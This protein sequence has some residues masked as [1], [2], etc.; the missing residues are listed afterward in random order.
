MTVTASA[1][2]FTTNNNNMTYGSIYSNALQF[3]ENE[4]LIHLWKHNL[5][6]AKHYLDR[7]KQDYQWDVAHNTGVLIGAQ[8]IRIC[9]QRVDQCKQMLRSL[10]CD[11][12]D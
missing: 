5:A 1:V 7:A 2:K 6:E 9:R 10:G 8:R 3:D 4:A 11:N 12:F